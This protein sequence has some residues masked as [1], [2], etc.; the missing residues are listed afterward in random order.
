MMNATVFIVDAR[1]RINNFE[2]ETISRHVSY[3]KNL[4]RSSTGQ[5]QHVVV[6]QNR[7]AQ[8]S[9]LE[10]LSPN[11]RIVRLDGKLNRNKIFEKIKSISLELHSQAA[12]L[13]AGDPLISGF[14]VIRVKEKLFKKTKLLTKCQVQVHFE[15][16]SI[17]SARNPKSILKYLLT[18]YS[19]KHADQMRFVDSDQRELFTQKFGLTKPSVVI[20]VP[21]NISAAYK[22]TKRTHT[23]NSV[24]FVGRLHNERGLQEFLRIVEVISEN[25]PD[26]KVLI[27]GDGPEKRNLEALLDR[28][29]SRLNI[30]LKGSYA[31]LDLEWPKIGVLVST[32]PAESY[33]RAMRE[34]HI[35]GV[36]VLAVSSLGS[37]KLASIAPQGSI[38]VLNS[39]F[40]GIEILDAYN[41]LRQNIIPITYRE[42]LQADQSNLTR[43]IPAAWVE[44]MRMD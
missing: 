24:A 43:Q 27:Y 11:L 29:S 40:G 8:E 17:L 21:L 3:A 31:N 16:N 36:P 20:P 22:V 44:L 18:R 37:K 38:R 4:S 42:K 19:L 28:K 41:S 9:S 34:A 13:V 10:N 26:L 35:H 23:P 39:N 15:L 7:A 33:G 1:H 30:L 32:A 2:E 6:L 14:L 12:I 25:S 5:F